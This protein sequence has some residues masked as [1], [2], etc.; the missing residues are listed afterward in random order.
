MAQ[1]FFQRPLIVQA[2]GSESFPKKADQVSLKTRDTE[3]VREPLYKLIIRPF[4]LKKSVRT[5]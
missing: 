4:E 2:E 3:E 5:K 1:G